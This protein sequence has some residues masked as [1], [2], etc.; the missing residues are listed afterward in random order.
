[1]C[2]IGCALT[3]SCGP[4][5]SFT[6]PSPSP[7]PAPAPIPTPPPMPVPLAI[8][9]LKA[10]LLQGQE[11]QTQPLA[12]DAKTL[13]NQSF[14]PDNAVTVI[15]HGD[16]RLRWLG[17]RF[18]TGTNYPFTAAR[19]GQAVTF[20]DVRLLNGAGLPNFRFG[21]NNGI[22]FTLPAG[23]TEFEFVLI[24]SGPAF[25]VS[26]LV[27]SNKTNS[28]GYVIDVQ[29]SGSFKNTR[30]VLPNSNSQ[31]KITINFGWRPFIGLRLPQ[32]QSIGPIPVQ[33]TEAT[34]VF[35]GDSITEG[36]VSS[37]P[38]RAWPMQVAYRLGISNPIVSGAGGTGYLARRPASP[39]QAGYNFRERLIDATEAKNGSS[40]P[41]IFVGTA[42]DA[43]VVAGG[44]NDCAGSVGALFT[45]DQTGT[46]ALAYFQAIRAAAPQ[47]VIFVLGPF[48]DW[49]N[50]TYSASSTA[51]RD[52]IFDAA[53]QVPLTYTIDVSNWVNNANRDQVFNGNVNGPHPVDTGH[54]IYGQRAAEGIAAILNGF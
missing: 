53:R 20:G 7:T 13:T 8:V 51:C 24:D 30:I 2:A 44:I 10:A 25:P 52:A 14:Y 17:G 41:A 28:D 12:L 4:S 11:L 26:I 9:R 40:D 47:T 31:R 21:I 22:E 34:V 36:A 46:E 29:A 38:D 43:I 33:I 23:Q 15:D 54:Y 3:V 6:G 18:A 1:M 50:P 32:G 35:I 39:T 45:P 19:N 37:F 5:D 48:T 16:P 49:N 27:D 42:P